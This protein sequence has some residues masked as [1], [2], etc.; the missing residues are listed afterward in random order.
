MSHFLIGCAI[1]G[2][3]VACIGGPL[4]APWSVRVRYLAAAPA[5]DPWLGADLGLTPRL[6][7]RAV[8]L[9]NVEADHGGVELAVEDIDG[10]HG[11]RRTLARTS[12]PPHAVAELDGWMALRTPLLM[13]VDRELVHVYG[14][15]SAVTNLSFVKERVR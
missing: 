11:S 5:F 1:G 8:K 7:M 4:I 9:V 15:E 2:A 3:I 6:D 14:P 12:C 10:D 13:I